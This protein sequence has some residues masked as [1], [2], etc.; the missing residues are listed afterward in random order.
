MYMIVRTQVLTQYRWHRGRLECPAPSERSVAS[1][2][3]PRRCDEML[4]EILA[5]S[6]ML[7]SYTWY[8]VDSH[9]SDRASLIKEHRN[10]S[11]RGDAQCC[12]MG[13]DLTTPITVP[14][15]PMAIITSPPQ[16]IGKSRVAT[17]HGKEWTRPL[18][19][20]LSVQCPLQTSPVTQLP[21]RYI[22]T[23]QTAY[24]ALA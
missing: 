7:H 24:T 21:L 2:V 1:C 10:I 3:S 23:T 15:R 17:L 5:Y 19:V 18:R 13:I 16:I 12:T 14:D 9:S 20:L 22:N 8:T 4:R 6:I 11:R